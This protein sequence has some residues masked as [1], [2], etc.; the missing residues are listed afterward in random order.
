M[1]L[2]CLWNI[3]MSR[4]QNHPPPPIRNGTGMKT[5]T[6]SVTSSRSRMIVMADERD[7]VDHEKRQALDEELLELH[8][9]VHDARDELAGVAAVEVLHPET[10]EM[11]VKARA[12]VRHD[13]GGQP[14]ADGPARQ[15]RGQVY[16]AAAD[17]RG[18]PETQARAAVSLDH[19]VD[20]G[21]GN[22][23]REHLRADRGERGQH[24][25]PCPEPVGAA[26]GRSEPAEDQPPGDALGARFA[27]LRAA[28]RRTAGSMR[29]CSSSG[30]SGCLPLAI[31]SMTRAIT[32][33][34]GTQA[35]V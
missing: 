23:R 33:N 25:H 3:G 16:H 5:S 27:A 19:V 18:D 17:H 9:V 13:A 21:L 28:A 14:H 35:L 7:G 32:A 22:E 2:P 30:T 20:D 29:C 4:R 8:R 31:L 26:R 12:Q 15:P 10:L 6:A 11:R 1:R 24:Q 34:S